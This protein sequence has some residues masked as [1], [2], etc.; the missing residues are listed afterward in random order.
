MAR[1]TCGA[2]RGALVCD[3]APHDDGDHRGYLEAVDEVL[4]WPT[5]TKRIEALAD[6]IAAEL[7]ELETEPAA[8]ELAVLKL[9][10]AMSRPRA[11]RAR[12]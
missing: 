11:S 2:R 7:E 12:S 5:T 10:V 8:R 3:R 1:D 6:V 9:R 4:F